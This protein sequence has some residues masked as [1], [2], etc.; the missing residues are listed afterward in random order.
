MIKMNCALA[1]VGFIDGNLA[2]NQAVIIDTIKSCAGKADV[3][4]FGEAFLQGFHAMDLS[5]EHDTAVAVSR[6]DP[7]IQ[8]ICRAAEEYAVAVSF[9]FLEKD[10]D[11]FFSSQ[12]TVD[13]NGRP[14]DLYRRVS[15][16]WKEPFA[17]K[18]YREGSAFHAFS[19]LGK[20]VAVGLCG[21]LWYDENI[22]RLNELRPDIV[23]W[24]VYTDYGTAEWN[25]AAKHEYAAQA[26]KI[27]APVLY[28]NAIC[29]GAPVDREAAKGGAALF[30]QGTIKN[31]L[32]AGNA[33]ILIVVI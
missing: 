9:G 30:D 15:P 5:V 14:I 4:I 31:E 28:V 18:A 17:G 12:M 8:K 19:F 7:A 23:W 21:D 33:G 16:G 24:P 32:P 20:T 26:A 13:R 3:V 6:S 11:A 1:A 22:A 25:A 10:G 29:I 2:Y 27:D